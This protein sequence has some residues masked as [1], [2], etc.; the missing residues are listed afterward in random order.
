MCLL[1]TGLNPARKVIRPSTEPYVAGGSVGLSGKRSQGVGVLIE[2]E[3][4]RRNDEAL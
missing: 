2:R 4:H 1:R 3:P